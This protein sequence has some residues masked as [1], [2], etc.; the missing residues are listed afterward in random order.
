MK[1]KNSRLFVILGL[2]ILTTLAALGYIRYYIARPIGS[3]PAGPAVASEPFAHPWSDRQ[4][5]LIGIGDSVTA[6]LGAK[7]A[8]HSYFQ[9]LVE[10]PVDEF[11][12]MK[13]IC[14]S[15]V[16]PNLKTLNLAI[17]GSTSLTHAEVVADRLE[18]QP[19]DIYGIVVMTTGGNDLIHSY[20]RA[21]A[22]EGAMFGAEYEEAK[23]WIA[24][25]EIRLNSMLDL[26]LAKFP[27][28]CEIYL[29]DIY[30]PTD[31]VGD[32]ASIMLKPWPDGLAIHAEYNRVINRC[33][34]ARDQVHVVRLHKTFLG[35]GGHCRQFWQPFYD[36]KDPYYWFYDN[37]EDPNDRGYD[38]IRRVFMNSILEHSSLRAKPQ[39]SQ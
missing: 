8:S 27:G 17:S 16:L 2:G 28:G 23:P 12:D 1:N 25:F 39:A 34:D 30:D 4:V 36:S 15:R 37:V 35:H 11:A 24:N 7:N 5:L 6:G 19:T 20:G 21:P 3:G 9:R 31:G 13:G 29:A 14:L 22:R 18:M 38:A 26:I 32:G 33:A 10:N